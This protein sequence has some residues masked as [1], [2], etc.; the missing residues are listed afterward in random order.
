MNTRKPERKNMVPAGREIEVTVEVLRTGEKLVVPEGASYED[1]IRALQRKIDEEERYVD[2]NFDFNM[3]PPEGAL[4]LTRTLKNLYGFVDLR[5][6]IGM[7]GIEHTPDYINVET[8]PSIF[9]EVPWGRLMT[10]NTEDGTLNTSVAW[11]QTGLPTFQLI[12]HVKGKY[13]HEVQKIIAAMKTEALLNNMY[14]GRAII[15]KFP[16][17]HPHNTLKDFLPEFTCINDAITEK[18][19]I[20]S[21][22]VERLVRSTI[23]TPIERTERCRKEG[24]S[25]KRGILLEGPYGTGK[26]LTARVVAQKCQE[27]GWTYIFL[28]DVT[29]L[30][31]ALEFARRYQPAVVFAEDIDQVLMS[32]DKRDEQ[33]NEILNTIDGVDSKNTEVIVI[34]TTN[35]VQNITQAMLR[36][37]RLD[38]VIP[39]RAPDAAAVQRLIRH[40]CGNLLSAHED[41]TTVG[42]LLKGQIPSFI[43][44][45]VDRSKLVAVGHTMGIH[46]A[47]DFQAAD[48]ETA[49]SGMI[50]HM[51]L[52]KI[53]EKDKRSNEEKAADVLGTHVRAGLSDVLA[54]L[55]PKK[56]PNGHPDLPSPAAAVAAT[57]PDPLL[58]A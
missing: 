50:A 48:L 37:G 41:L 29:K 25:L 24:I 22:E 28:K 52:L 2:I 45:V 55:V 57:R 56:A 23:F 13:R 1:C 9:E 10:P 3:T 14:R 42:E 44:E 4:A 5:G 49:A 30:K 40:F 18:D 26:T 32:P 43:R 33:V 6:F 8:A 35:N 16:E 36:P 53:K 54:N 51:E 7:F 31:H 12:A 58:T 15:P 34:L 46:D 27:N 21:A 39:V 20:F 17:P 47:L 19:L 38:A 11:S